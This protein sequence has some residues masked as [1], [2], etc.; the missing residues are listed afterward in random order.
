MQVATVEGSATTPVTRSP[1]R[2]SRWRQRLQRAIVKRSIQ[3][4]LI[5][6]LI[7]AMLVGVDYA[8]S[9]ARQFDPGGWIASR[10]PRMPDW[11]VPNLPAFDGW[12]SVR[13][14]FEGSTQLVVIQP[15]NLRSAPGL[16]DNIVRSLDAGAVLQRVGEVVEEEG[17][18]WIR[19]I[20][21]EDGT[22]GWVADQPDKLR[23]D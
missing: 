22:E 4:A 20:V 10:L 13:D 19:V 18:T 3:I 9:R 5:I 21:V 15:V 2:W 17:F 1:G 11:S 14:L 12:P 23:R 6:A 16:G 8:V 7:Y